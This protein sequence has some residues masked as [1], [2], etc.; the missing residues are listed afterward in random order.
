MSHHL[1]NE[2]VKKAVLYAIFTYAM[3]VLSDA[4]RKI[5]V[6]DY[7]IATIMFWQMAMGVVLMLAWS[8]YRRDYKRLIGYGAVKKHMIRG[9]LFAFNTTFSIMAIQHLP[10]T[11]VYTL[12]FLAPFVIAVAGVVFLNEKISTAALI[13]IAGSFIGAL[14]A[15]RPGFE[16]LVFGHL[17]ALVCV[18][19]FAAAN[20]LVRFIGHENGLLAFAFWPFVFLLIGVVVLQPDKIIWIGELS[21]LIPVLIAAIAYAVAQSTISYS[22]TLA[23]AAVVAPYQ[24]VA[25][26]FAIAFD[27]Y[28]LDKMPDVFKLTGA[29]IIVLSGVFLFVQKSQ[30]SEGT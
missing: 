24:Y 11:D 10:I 4:M 1:Q 23:P 18:F 20:I 27:Y 12:F 21:F 16:T 30:K 9:V 19:L 25:I 26:I 29:A 17:S 2:N 22:F 3:F 15:F 28:V 14:I 8:L 6:T 7:H 5:L 13:S